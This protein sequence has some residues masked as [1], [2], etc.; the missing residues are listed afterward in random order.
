MSPSFS[1]TKLSLLNRDIIWATAHIRG[2]IEKGISGGRKENLQ[3]KKTLL[4]IT[5]MLQNI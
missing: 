1:S 2:G 3:T 5:Y 4:K